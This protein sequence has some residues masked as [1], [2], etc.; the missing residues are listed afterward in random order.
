[1]DHRHVA[2]PARNTNRTRSFNGQAHQVGTFGWFGFEGSARERGRFAGLVDGGSGGC[3][4][5]RRA[6]PRTGADSPADEDKAK[7]LDT[8]TVIST[9]TRKADMAVTDSPAPIQLVGAEKLASTGAPDLQNAI[10]NQVPSY[11]ATQ[12]GGD[13]ASQTLTAAL[14]G[15]SPNHTLVLVNGK[16]LHNTAN[17]G[18]SSGS[19]AP[20]LS[21]IPEAAID[22][23]EVLTDGAAALYGSDA[24]AGVINI[25]LKKNHEED[26]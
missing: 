22:H 21:F 18:A 19:A 26:S 15:L 3:R 17:V 1:V 12:V 2:L 16:R 6:G 25:I 10:A 14:R 13:M 4:R 24:I 8:V 23:V 11:N 7:T 5:F 9:G 20:D